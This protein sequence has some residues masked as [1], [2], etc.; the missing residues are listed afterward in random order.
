MKRTNL[1]ISTSKTI[2]FVQ[3]T[4]Q[5]PIISLSFSTHF[6]KFSPKLFDWVIVSNLK[7]FIWHIHTKQHQIYF[8]ESCA[9]R[10]SLC[11]YT[12]V[13]ICVYMLTLT[14]LHPK[15]TRRNMN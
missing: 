4:M 2:K 9:Y 11:V 1:Y 8:N 14:I 12:Y 15:K 6:S 7:D 10:A 13:C 3:Q 5:F